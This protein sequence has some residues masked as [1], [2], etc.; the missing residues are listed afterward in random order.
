MDDNNLPPVPKCGSSD[1]R[2]LEY[3]KNYSAKKFFDSLISSELPIIFDVGAHQ[4]ESIAFFRSLYMNAKIYSFEP[5][6]QNFIALLKKSI[7]NKTF[8]F[9][10]AIGDSNETTFFYRQGL[11]HLGGLLPINHNSSDSLGYAERAKNEKI[12][13]EKIKLDTF[14]I[15]NSINHIDILK[16]DVQGFEVGVLNGASEILKKTDCVTIEISLYDFYQTEGS[17]LLQ[18]EQIMANAKFIL[19]DISKVSKNPKNLRTDWVE[20][21]YK[22]QGG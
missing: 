5:E 16:I 15:Q 20:V 14:C 8:A 2:N 4:G 6:P 22:K 12:S 7:D 9:N 19:W 13:V 21:V 17:Q 1:Q 18:V 10:V 11:S 3:Q